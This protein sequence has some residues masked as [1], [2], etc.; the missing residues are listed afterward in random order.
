MESPGDNLVHRIRGLLDRL[1]DCRR[2]DNDNQEIIGDEIA[3]EARA[4]PREGIVEALDKAIGSSK[5]RRREA[6]Y[7]LSELTD[8]AEAV[9]RVGV[10]LKDLDERTRSWLIQTVQ[11]RRLKQFAPLLNDIIES[12]PDIACRSFAIHACGAL[13][14]PENL[15]A[16][17]RLAAQND[18]LVASLAWAMK[19]YATE[20]CRPYLQRWFKD[21]KQGKP[22]QVVS[23]WGLGKLGDEI[24]IRY[25]ITM[26]EDPD[27]RG[28]TFFRPGESLRAA[29]ALCDIYGW[30]F[31]W[32]ISYV[33]KTT[34]L[35]KESGLTRP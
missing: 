35:V 20:E 22:T 9:E 1:V 26:L 14:A 6:V 7:V 3:V 8:V 27:R 5:Q 16:L 12:D 29:Q 18:P 2:L 10:W 28:L 21:G 4:L 19:E 30:P 34:S 15:P 25:L 32:H 11:H 31:E 33:S 24:A 23:A 13:K 17:L